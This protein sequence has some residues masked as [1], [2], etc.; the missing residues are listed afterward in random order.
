MGGRVG[1]LPDISH[2]FGYFKNLAVNSLQRKDFAG[3]RASLFNLNGC[4]GDEYLVTINTQLY[5]QALKDQSTYQCNHCTTTQEKIV[6]EGDENEHTKEI[7][8]PTEIPTRE[9]KV[10]PVSLNNVQQFLAQSKTKLIWTCPKCDQDNNMKDTQKILAEREKPYFLKVVPDS[11]Y[12]VMGLD[13]QFPDK[14]EKW[15]WNFFE[16]INWQEVLY[17]KEYVSQH[18]GDDM[19][20]YKDKGDR[21]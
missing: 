2:N 7:Q 9:V 6:N 5:E 3:A 17:R 18:D 15:F 16:E 13:R 12:R 14:L 19:E 21:R 20:A 4:L 11:P 10:F 8:V 1:F